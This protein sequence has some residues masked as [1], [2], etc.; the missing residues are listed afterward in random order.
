MEN[1]RG[2]EHPSKAAA[3]LYIARAPQLHIL[4]GIAFPGRK[5]VTI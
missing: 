3:F 2:R 1:G 5:I 4:S